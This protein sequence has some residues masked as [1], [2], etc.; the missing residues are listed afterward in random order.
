MAENE[1]TWENTFNGSYEGYVTI[2]GVT[3]KAKVWNVVQWDPGDRYRWNFRLMVWRNHDLLSR[4][5]MEQS[6]RRTMKDARAACE[7]ALPRLLAALDV[8]CGGVA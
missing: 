5:V 1:F 2:D 6:V 4:E 7:D 3:V 8:L